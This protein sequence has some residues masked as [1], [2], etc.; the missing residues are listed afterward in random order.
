[1][2]VGLLQRRDQTSGIGTEASPIGLAT[3]PF[4]ATDDIGSAIW[5]IEIK[6]RSLDKVI[7]TASTR[8][9]IGIALDLQRTAIDARDEKVMRSASPL[10]IRILLLSVAG[11]ARSRRTRR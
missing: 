3:F 2:P 7:R 11:L 6:N 4:L 10:I 1:M 8:R 9:V 5:I